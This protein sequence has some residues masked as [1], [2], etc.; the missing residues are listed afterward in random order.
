MALRYSVHQH[1]LELYALQFWYTRSSNPHSLINRVVPFL[2]L[3]GGRAP[4]VLVILLLT[5]CECKLKGSLSNSQ[6]RSD[7][8]PCLG[9]CLLETEVA[10]FLEEQP[11]SVV[12]LAT[13][14][15]SRVCAS[16]VKVDFPFLFFISSPWSQRLNHRVAHGEY[17]L[18]FLP[19]VEEHFVIIAETLVHTDGE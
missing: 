10:I 19:Q 18:C 4:L 2:P 7:R 15:P 16:R 13:H 1:P 8:L 14:I 6:M 12:L 5:F 3:A 11:F 17:I 9:N